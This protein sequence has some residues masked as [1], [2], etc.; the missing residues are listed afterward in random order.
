M[1]SEDTLDRI[2][3]EI[4][5]SIPPEIKLTRVEFE[6]PEIAIY[7]KNSKV[8]V[9]DTDILRVLAKKMRK[10]IVIRSDP[11]SRMD[12][13]ESIAFIQKLVVADAEITKIFFDDNL[14]EFTI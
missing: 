2:K 13:E 12:K 3:K 6:G 9:D 5:E 8:L 14:G 1:S 7:S 11:E 10:R 4:M